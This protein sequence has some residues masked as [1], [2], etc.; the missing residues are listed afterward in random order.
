M[1]GSAIGKN[2]PRKESWQKA[3]GTA[4]Y[5]NDIARPGMLYAKLA[6]SPHAHAKIISIDTSQALSI[7]GVR[8]VVTGRHFPVLTG[9]PLEDRP[10]LAID[11]VR[12]YGEPVALVVADSEYVAQMAA[13]RI[14][15]EYEPL[16]IVHSPSQ[17]YQKDA[18]LIHERLATY[19]GEEEVY[20]EPGTNVANRTKIRKG[21]IAEGW[22]Q[23]AHTVEVFVR[24]PQSDHAAMETRCSIAEI[25]PDGNVIIHSASQSPYIIRKQI[26][27]Y[28]HVPL[29]KV[30]VHTPLVGGAYGGKAAVQLEFLAFLASRAVGGRPVKLL[31]ARETDMVSSPVHIGL[32]SRVRLGCT[33]DGKIAAADILHLFDG[34]AYSD[35]GVIMSRAGATDCSGP[36]RIDNLHCD[37]LCMYTNHPYSTSFRGFGHLE[38]TFAMERAMDALAE[39]AQMDPLE[40]RFHNAIGPGD[41]TPTQTLLNRSNVGNLP[42]C[43]AKLHDIVQWDDKSRVKSNGHLVQATGVACFWKNS[44]TPADAGAG[45]VVIFNADGSVNVLCGAVEIG[46]G[47]RTALTQ[48][49]AERLQMDEGRIH[50][51]TDVRTESDPELW[52]TVASRSTF[53]VGN[54]LMTAA[55]DAIAQLTRTAS[56]VLKCPA[57][58]LEVGGGR[59]YCKDN[60]ADGIGIDAIAHGYKLPDGRIVGSQVI[61]RGS[62]TM[63]GIT[64]LD[65]ETG[66]GNPGPEW[67][68]GAQAVEVEFNTRDFTYRIV[69]A[70]TVID[71]GKVIN[72]AF[73][74]GQLTGGMSMG[75]SLASRETFLFNDRGVILDTQ[76]RT[77]KLIRYGEQP[78]Y[79]VDFVETPHLEAPYGLRGIGEHGVIGMPAALASA[80]SAA[81]GVELNR[82]P[83]TP[84]R[85]WRAVHDSV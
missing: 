3:T 44:N 85:I 82:L 50:I 12:Y 27:H 7:P 76:F 79:F 74:R 56:L 70:A 80:L 16:P 13:L 49:L 24:L 42:K 71:A 21:N 1:S 25:R 52:K 53:L 33:R 18:P 68:V 37:S 30:Q 11:K 9:S 17:A 41:T 60:P 5:V 78:S 67:T 28:F 35:R 36:Y 34:G 75:L 10:P 46:Q 62:Y 40:F 77:Y 39:K 19:H 57:D 69:K 66:R 61:G 45:A 58:S 65:P 4:R 20:P 32:E 54:E 38:L 59:V 6:V 64:E 22:K 83:L 31:N 14:Q 2:V 51:A 47:T 63:R 15:A 73:A 55:D 48:M 43:I 81:A 23:C 8:A 29:Q 26:S 84:E 72:P